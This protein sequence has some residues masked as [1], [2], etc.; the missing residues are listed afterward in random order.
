[1]N[2]VFGMFEVISSPRNLLFTG[3][4]CSRSLLDPLDQSPVVVDEPEDEPED[5]ALEDELLVLEDEL[6]ALV[7]EVLDVALVVAASFSFT[8]LLA[9]LLD[10]S[11]VP[12]FGELL[13][14]SVLPQTVRLVDHERFSFQS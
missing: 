3:L 5:E 2:R 4:F 12:L 9:S 13:P 10:P 14:F 6:L 1:M 11:V 8:A 7:D